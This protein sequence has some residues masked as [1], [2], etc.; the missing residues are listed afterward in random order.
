MTLPSD[1]NY[2]MDVLNHKIRNI[3]QS[4]KDKEVLEVRQRNDRK[5]REKYHKLRSKAKHG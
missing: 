2:R 1:A 3:A 4:Q 5:L